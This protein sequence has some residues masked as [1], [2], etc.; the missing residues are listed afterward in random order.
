[1]SVDFLQGKLTSKQHWVHNTTSRTP[2]VSCLHTLPSVGMILTLH[3]SNESVSRRS[4]LRFGVVRP[5][6]LGLCF[7]MYH[8]VFAAC[9]VFLSA[10]YRQ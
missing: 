10:L 1:M 3:Q 5:E 8:A 6:A 2:L 4:I 7:E 9:F